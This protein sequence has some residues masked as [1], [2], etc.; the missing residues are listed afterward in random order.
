M[1]LSDCSVIPGSNQRPEVKVISVIVPAYNSA[2]TIELCIRSLQ[3]QTWPAEQVEIIIVDD[4]SSDQT[5]DLAEAMGVTVL[6]ASHRGPA[7]ARNL[8]VQHARGTIILFTDADC[9]ADQHWIEEMSRPIREN[10]DVAGVKGIYR[11]RQT[12]LAARFAQIEFEDRYRKLAKSQYIDFV[13]SHAAA[14]RREVFEEVGGFDLKFPVANNEDVELSYK[15]A[16]AGHKMVFTDQAIVYHRHPGTVRKYLATKLSRGYWRIKVYQKFPQKMMSDSY[17]PQSLKLEIVFAGLTLAFLGLAVWNLVLLK[18]AAITAVAF[19]FCTLPF[20]WFA[21]R[22][23]VSVGLWAPALLFG[24][25]LV[26]AI[27]VVAGTLSK[28]RGDILLPSL[29]VAAD[30]LSCGLGLLVAYWFRVTAIDSMLPRFDHPVDV[31]LALLPFIVGIWVAVFHSRGLYRAGWVRSPLTEY[32][33]IMQSVAL[34]VLIVIA[35]SF[36]IKWDF[37]RSVIIIYWLTATLLALA[38]RTLVRNIQRPMVEKGYY[39]IR[40]VLVG[41]GDTAQIVITRL[42]AL[43]DSVYRFV[44]IVDDDPASVQALG[45]PYL[46]PLKELVRII[47][48]NDIDEVLIANPQLTHRDTLDVI[49]RTDHTGVSFKVVSDLFDIMSSSASFDTVVNLPVVDFRETR[50]YW[51]RNLLKR[52]MDVGIGL[53]LALL[54]SPLI[55]LSV[56]ALK[57]LGTQPALMQ[58]PMVG[59]QGK[60]FMMYRLRCNPEA[61][62]A[63]GRLSRFLQNHHLD[64]LPQIWNVISGSMSLV[65]PRPELQE[66]VKLYDEWQ[67]RRLLLKPGVTGLWQIYGRKNRPLHED[68]E[69]D[70]Y[71]LK[72]YSLTLDLSIM[73]RTIPA[74]FIGRGRI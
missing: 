52:V 66:I 9:E 38:T 40:A 5:A 67:R 37:S 47:E 13:D 28:R 51:V 63:Y 33:T 62:G 7:A 15:I 60:L 48:T 34:V 74:V 46:G 17:T 45:L 65:G 18:V 35:C 42:N 27:G 53:C 43:Y 14:F 2:A 71:Y 21:L 25:S 16:Q 59:Y 64:E 6:R 54:T 58:Q 73:L 39:S 50:S 57:R 22:R 20:V 31:Y 44:G 1:H 30:V 10:S 55:L 26:F 56:L 36:F 32:M 68:L 12:S 49:A 4:G 24:R 11:T 61:P 69:L 41:S 70:F 19:L 3:Q 29:L 8:G 23:D 72:N